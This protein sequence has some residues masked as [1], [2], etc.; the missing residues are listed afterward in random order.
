VMCVLVPVLAA[1]CIPIRGLPW[2]WFFIDSAFGV[3]AAVLL[4]IAYRDIS[5]AERIA[6]S[7][8]A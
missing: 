4:W 2:Q 6:A 1:V 8:P 7:R 5:W 3:I